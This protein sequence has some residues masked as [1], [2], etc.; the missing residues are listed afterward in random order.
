MV[1]ICGISIVI[2]LYFEIRGMETTNEVTYNKYYYN[3]MKNWSERNKNYFSLLK[4][5]DR[6][7]L[8]KALFVIHED[9]KN[10]LDSKYEIDPETINTNSSIYMEHISNPVLKI[11]FDDPI[12]WFEPYL[13]KF[14]KTISLDNNIS[15]FKTSHNLYPIFINLEQMIMQEIDDD[16]KFKTPTI[17][18]QY[19]EYLKNKGL[20]FNQ[21]LVISMFIVL[22]LFSLYLIFS[23]INPIVVFLILLI[24]LYGTYI[25]YKRNKL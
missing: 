11:F 24:G 7:G 20:K 8:K 5:L 4:T 14:K 23:N 19:E 15:G 9:F 12:L 25:Y 18:E 17:D 3:F 21:N 6:M 22:I 1:T 13:M 2:L 16:L 10:M